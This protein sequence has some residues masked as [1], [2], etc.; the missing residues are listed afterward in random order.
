MQRA[1][2][3]PPR[4]KYV[5]IHPGGIE[6]PSIILAFKKSDETVAT[7]NMHKLLKVCQS[8]SDVYIYI[9]P[10]YISHLELFR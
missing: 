5:Y 1:D 6:D 8:I 2:S 7:K 10:F 3:L 9:R 4:F